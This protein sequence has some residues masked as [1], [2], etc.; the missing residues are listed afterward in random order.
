M[1]VCVTDIGLFVLTASDSW[2]FLYLRLHT[3][4]P[5]SQITGSRTKFW[6]HPC[7]LCCT[8][9]ILLATLPEM[10]KWLDCMWFDLVENTQMRHMQRREQSAFAPQKSGLGSP[11]ES[12]SDIC[13]LS[14]SSS[15]PVYSSQERDSIEGLCPRTLCLERLMLS[16]CSLCIYQKAREVLKQHTHLLLLL[17]ILW[18]SHGNKGVCALWNYH[19]KKYWTSYLGSGR[20]GEF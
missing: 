18:N 8:A 4:R 2:T 1:C 15:T 12:L 17:P 6:V 7:P 13:S 14:L 19:Q 5:T 10:W 20:G 16:G 11:S 9:Q 3:L